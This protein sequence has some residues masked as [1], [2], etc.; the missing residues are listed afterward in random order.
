[1]R[2]LHG[3][4]SATAAAAPAAGGGAGIQDELDSGEHAVG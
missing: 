1:V 4:L 3:C 2:A